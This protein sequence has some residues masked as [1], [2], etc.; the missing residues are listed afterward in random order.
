MATPS[1]IRS[2]NNQFMRAFDSASASGPRV[3]KPELSKAIDAAKAD[4]FVTFRE[5]NAIAYALTFVARYVNAYDARTLTDGAIQLSTDFF[6]TY[7]R[8]SYPVSDSVFERLS[9][10]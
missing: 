6:K 4:G 5:R 9:I 2:I 1:S 8:V 3:T 10:R 7:G